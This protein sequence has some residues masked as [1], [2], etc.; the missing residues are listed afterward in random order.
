MLFLLS[1]FVGCVSVR[2]L[3]LLASLTQSC[4]T[5]STDRTRRNALDPQIP[6]VDVS[7]NRH[8]VDPKFYEKLA[9]RCGSRPLRIPC[10]RKGRFQFLRVLAA[11]GAQSWGYRQLA[12]MN[13]EV[14]RN[15]SALICDRFRLLASTLTRCYAAKLAL[16]SGVKTIYYRLTTSENVSISREVARALF[17]D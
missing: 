1:Y 16:C 8:S 12:L 13:G 17:M 14:A 11:G 10:A 7:V 6:S 5:L 2:S 15:R 9:E 3:T 4:C